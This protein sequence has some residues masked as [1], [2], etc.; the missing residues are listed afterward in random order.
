MHYVRL[1][2]LHVLVR[3]NPVSYIFHN[4]HLFYFKTNLILENSN[5]FYILLYLT[6]LEYSGMHCCQA[7]RKAAIPQL[8]VS[9][10]LKM[11]LS[12]S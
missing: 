8:T 5:N 12:L 4:I 6:T 1:F 7:L 11:L 3:P 10:V 2:S 9:M